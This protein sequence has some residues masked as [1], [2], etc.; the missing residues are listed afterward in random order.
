MKYDYVHIINLIIYIYMF[1]PNSN[2]QTEEQSFE[3]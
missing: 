3:Y 1:S 2:S